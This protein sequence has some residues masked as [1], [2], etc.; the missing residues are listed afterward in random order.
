MTIDP[1]SEH[2]NTLHSLR[3]LARCSCGA[4]GPPDGRIS[5]LELWAAAVVVR[6]SAGL[7]R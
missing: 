4:H 6:L 3:A 1:N 5:S 2:A 7:T